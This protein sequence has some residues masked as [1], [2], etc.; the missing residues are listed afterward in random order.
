MEKKVLNELEGVYKKT[1]LQNRKAVSNTRITQE[2]G[3]QYLNLWVTYIQIFFAMQKILAEMKNEDNDIE[4]ITK[5]KDVSETHMSFQSYQ[6]YINGS[7]V[8][9]IGAIGWSRNQ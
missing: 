3:W 8:E 9:S 4:L 2:I 5:S 6:S 1:T 7:I